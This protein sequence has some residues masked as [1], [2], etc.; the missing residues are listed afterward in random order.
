MYTNSDISEHMGDYLKSKSQVGR[1]LA[2]TRAMILNGAFASGER[3]SEP[4]L[5][6]RLKVSR[7]PL[8]EAIGRLVQEGLVDRLESGRC[9]VSSY[10]TQDI[11]DAIEVR[12]TVEGLAARVAAE[13]GVSNEMLS[14]CLETL[15]NLDR[16]VGDGNDVKFKEYVRLNAAFH[17]WLAQAAGSVIIAREVDRI[18]RMPLASPSAFLDGQQDIPAFRGTLVMAQQQHRAIFEAIKGRESARAEALCR[19]HARLARQNLSFVMT[20]RSLSRDS[21]PGLSLVNA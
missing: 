1:A 10:S 11:M 12:G 7:T 13:R 21:I 16:A 17:S 3:L 14:E 5:A 6:E 19:E 20:D 9:Q 18:S 4:L 15:A 2:E 8:R